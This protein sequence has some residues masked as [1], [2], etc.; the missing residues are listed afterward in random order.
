MEQITFYDLGGEDHEIHVIL[1]KCPKH[2]NIEIFN[3]TGDIV[4][5]ERSHI[6][7]WESYVNLAKQIL[8]CDARIQKEI[9]T[10]EDL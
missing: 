5:E 6:Y 3:E 4:F 8:A 1:D 7:A 2:V 9:E 10:R